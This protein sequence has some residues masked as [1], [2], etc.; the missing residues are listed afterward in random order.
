MPTM[1]LPPNIR[2]Q[3]LDGA[4]KPISGGLIY[5]YQAGTTTPQATYT[6]QGGLTANANP[7]VADSSGVYS[8]W[9]D[10]SLSYKIVYK[11]ALGNMLETVDN[12]VGLATVNAVATSS[13][14]DGAVTT[15]KMAANSVTSAILASDASVDGNR[16]VQTNHI[17]DAQVTRAK[18]AAGALGIGVVSASKTASFTADTATDFYPCDATSGAIT[19]TLYA[20]AG[21]SGRIV[22]FKK[23]DS[24]ANAITL[25]ANLSETIDGA[26]TQTITLKN[27]SLSIICDGSNWQVF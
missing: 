23:T 11:D 27:E 16:A 5:T 26:L 19:V 4:G 13:I 15:A 1:N 8:M 18:L 7:I 14:Q 22:R 12:I 6:D 9:I 17:R 21:N 20:A 2:Q 25:D 24:S 3:L 10:P